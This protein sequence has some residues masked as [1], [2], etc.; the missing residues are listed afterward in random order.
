MKAKATELMVGDWVYGLVVDEGNDLDKIINRVPCKVTMINEFGDIYTQGPF[1]ID[2]EE[3]DG[4]WEWYDIEPIPLTPEI[5]EKN[6]DGGFCDFRDP[7][8]GYKGK[9]SLYWIGK[10]GIYVEWE[11][12]IGV[13]YVEFQGLGDTF[14]KGY[15]KSL[16]ELQHALRLCGI[17]KE[18]IL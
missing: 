2:D 16:H 14:F 10:V 15:I 1:P 8:I 4:E 12:M 11:R 6:T 9:R 13:P 7:I 3:Y 18:I 17:E 5:L